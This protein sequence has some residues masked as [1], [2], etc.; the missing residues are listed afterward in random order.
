MASFSV[1]HKS[2]GELERECP[3]YPASFAASLETYLNGR[4]ADGWDLIGWD[5]M[6]T[7][8]DSGNWVFIFANTGLVGGDAK[9]KSK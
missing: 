6:G 2:A 5:L 3:H 4:A 1:E 8:S 7:L 9:R